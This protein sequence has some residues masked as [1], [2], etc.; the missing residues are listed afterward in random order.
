[1]VI[2][3][4]FIERNRLKRYIATLQTNISSTP[5]FHRDYEG[6]RIWSQT[7][8]NGE[9]L[10]TAIANL[11]KAK[12][13]LGQFNIAIDAANAEGAKAL[14]DKIETL[15]SKLVNVQG[16]LDRISMVKA[17]ELILK[18][19]GRQSFIENILD[20]DKQNLVDIEKSL[21]KEINKAEDD[22]AGINA[23]TEVK[24]TDEL[25]DFL[26]TYDD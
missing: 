9:D 17:K 1:M 21:K 20:V 24:L 8:L 16:V 7:L 6:E 4:A 18:E 11:L 2:A 5:V 3:K 13:M 12:D 26:E 22:L 10:D 14:I 15:K 23:M 19:D 25:Q